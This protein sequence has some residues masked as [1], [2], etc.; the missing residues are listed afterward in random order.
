MNLPKDNSSKYKPEKQLE[1]LRLQCKELSPELY[2]LNA[3]YLK[4]IRSILPNAVR[5]SVFLLIT[6]QGKYQMESSTLNSKNVYLNKI[7]TLISSNLSLLTIEH[8]MNVSEELEKENEE[9]IK[10]NQKAILSEFDLNN[11]S[12]NASSRTISESIEIPSNPPLE[13]PERIYESFFKN[14]LQ[15]EENVSFPNLKNNTHKLSSELDRRKES[16]KNEGQFKI[17]RLNDNNGLAGLRRIFQ[18]AGDTMLFKKNN[19]QNNESR[20]IEEV[21]NGNDSITESPTAKA[22]FLPEDPY[23]LYKWMNSLELSLIRILRDL[24]NSIN[25]ELL[26]GG[27]IN[28]LIP[29]SI[30]DSAVAGQIHSQNAPSNLLRIYVPINS[31]LS[32]Q[33]IDITCVLIRPSELEFDNHRLRKCK[34]LLNQQRHLLLKMIKQHSHWQNRLLANEVSQQW[35]KKP[36][37]SNNP[38]TTKG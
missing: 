8:L 23:E 9:K 10:Q 27:F 25:I 24:S 6:D 29:V 7:D 28:N 19:D 3:L 17:K 31:A 11:V 30:L 32:D 33:A 14:D 36:L 5:Q 4:L 1:L 21:N 34:S 38:T 18:I 22:G 20:R 2:K 16:S 37:N 13:F 15:I 26:S 35:L 12:S